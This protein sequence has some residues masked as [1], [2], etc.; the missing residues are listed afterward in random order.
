MIN[1]IDG[2][3]AIDEREYLSV[4]KKEFEIDGKPKLLL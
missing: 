2:P 3:E 4:K 1:L